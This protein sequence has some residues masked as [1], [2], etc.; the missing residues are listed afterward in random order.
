MRDLKN[1]VAIVTGGG[2]GIGRATSLR[3]AEEGVKLVIVDMNQEAGQE[4]LRLVK[5]IGIEAIFVRADVSNSKDV[6]NYV[7]EALR[8]FGRIDVLFNNAGIEGQVALTAD[9]NEDAY[10]QV[11]A[12]NQR[13]IFLGL[14]YVLPVMVEQ[15]SGSIINTASVAGIVGVANLLGYAASKHAIVGMTKVAAVEYG[16]LG[17]R[18]NVIC[19][20]PI[21]T[22][23]TKNSGIKHNPDN[24]QEFPDIV[25]VMVPSRRSGQP[26]EVAGL[27]AFLASGEAPYINGAAI[28]IDGGMTSI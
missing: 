18:V 10:E 6:Q 3:F 4:T 14:K 13:G 12:V 24:P 21:E 2:S 7:Q 9:Y 15:K 23:M 11:I 5:E 28:T 19:P 17:I 16:A 1:K 26:E 20:G 8:K 25:S 22:E 27:V